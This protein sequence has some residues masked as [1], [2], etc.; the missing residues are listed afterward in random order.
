MNKAKLAAS[1]ATSVLGLFMTTGAYAHQGELAAREDLRKQLKNSLMTPERAAELGITSQCVEW[2]DIAIAVGLFEDEAAVDSFVDALVWEPTPRYQA[3]NRWTTTATNGGGIQIRTPITLTYSFVPDGTEIPFASTVAGSTTGPSSLFADMN[4]A[5]ASLGGEATWK[6]NFAAAFNRVGDLTG[7]NY[8][9]VSDDGAAF[10]S[11]AGSNVPGSTRGDIRISMR[12]FAGSGGVLAYNFFPNNSDMVIDKFDMSLWTSTS[13]S[14]R[15]LRNM[16]IHEHGHGLGYSH[17]DPTVG[18]K[19]MEAFLNTGFDGPQ[20]DDIRGFQFQYGDNYESN[21]SAGAATPI[22]PMTPTGIGGA[23]SFV[24]TEASLETG[25]SL[26]FYSFQIMDPNDSIRIRIEPVGTVYTQGPQGGATASLNAASILDLNIELIGSNQSTV[27]A[28]AAVNAAGLTE[29]IDEF[30]FNDFGAGTYYVRVYSGNATTDIQRYRLTLTALAGPQ[31]CNSNLIA[32]NLDTADLKAAL[33][34]D[35]CGS[36]EHIGPGI[37][38]VG[39]TTTATVAPIITIC[40]SSNNSRDVWYRYV[41]ATDG[42]LDAS[43][44]GS[45]YDTVLSVHS[46]CDEG[47]GTLLACNDDSASCGEATSSYIEALPVTAQTTYYI[48][49]AGKST[50]AGAYSLLI[51]GPESLAGASADLNSNGVPD[52]CEPPIAIANYSPIDINFNYGELTPEFSPIPPNLGAP[53][54]AGYNGSA[55]FGATDIGFISTP[56]ATGTFATWRRNLGVALEEDTLYRV[57]ATVTTNA[58]AGA[59]NWV[60]VRF[61]GDFQEANGQTDFSFVSNAYAS[62]V[63]NTPRAINA[64]HWVKEDSQGVSA[65]GQAD[66]PA[67]NFDLID[68]SATVGGHYAQF[69]SISVDAVSRPSLGTP[70]VLRNRGIAGVSAFEGFTPPAASLQPFAAGDGYTGGTI[71]DAGSNVSMTTSKTAPIAGALNFTFNTP[72]A[73]DQTGFSAL[74]VDVASAPTEAR[75]TIDPTKLYSFDV[76]VS[77]ETTPNSATQR[78]PILRLRWI[79]EQVAQNHGQASMTSYNLNPDATFDGT[80][81]NP[82]GLLAPGVARRYTTFWAPSLDTTAQPNTSSLFFMD[83]LF[84]RTGA[85]AIRPSGTYSIERMLI[86]EYDQPSL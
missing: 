14:Y 43:L 70:T 6:A 15:A 84:N 23:V 60:R 34:Q 28:R 71:N 37:T 30:N 74:F 22:G 4:A 32:D 19:L 81:D 85:S 17:V 72:G 58:T 78:A 47:V 75:V 8:V 12:P 54:I 67:I 44:C 82:A 76:W 24:T 2:Q 26:D 63:S 11:A 68:E 66:Q 46:S 57:R 13:G 31:D 48:R 27:L 10:A 1:L 52:E 38:Y 40:G 77:S 53:T 62:P 80:N 83:F 16:L 49:V 5:Y 9:E 29:Q 18:T 36:A 50:F 73:G 21:N 51:E 69:G 59:S 55:P 61:G 7:I 42:V 39:E 3:S 20:Q 45:S 79:A 65:V 56:E 35:V 41:P 86:M 64:Y 33:A 25:S